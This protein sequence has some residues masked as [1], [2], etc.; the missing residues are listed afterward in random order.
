MAIK[1]VHGG[2][3]NSVMFDEIT[4][5][6]GLMITER[7]SKYKHKITFTPRRADHR[8]VYKWCEQQFG[9]GGRSKKLRWRMGWTDTENNY[10]FK[11]GQDA[12]MFALRW[13]D[14]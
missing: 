9:P 7:K 12:T 1:P 8:E 2:W 4:K 3:I 11:H 14:A 6:Q 13:A 5:T 10:Y